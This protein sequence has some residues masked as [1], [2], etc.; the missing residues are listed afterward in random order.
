M[1][2][3]RFNVLFSGKL[4]SGIDPATAK[5]RV[6]ELFKLSDAAIAQLFSGKTIVVKKNLDPDKAKRFQKAFAQ[7]GLLVQ[8]VEQQPE[9]SQEPDS[10][11]A[12]PQPEP[13]GGLGLAPVDSGPLEP[14]PDRTP[15]EVDTSYLSVVEGENWSLE[16]CD[17][18][19]EPIP[20]PDT[21][22][23]SLEE[24]EPEKDQPRWKP[25]E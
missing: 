21:S 15:P 20:T 5:A 18:P 24:P 23:L 11:P 16:D 6:R 19:P 2:D 7:A 8:L 4:K 17:Q 1:A 25:N 3:I 22:Y 14:E 10:K 12:A 9:A 13:S